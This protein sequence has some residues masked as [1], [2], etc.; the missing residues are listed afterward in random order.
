MKEKDI[1]TV[2]I[3][4]M[5][6][7]GI[8]VKLSGNIQNNMENKIIKTNNFLQVIGNSLIAVPHNLK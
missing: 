1:L 7:L 3:E 4:R 2:F 8:E 5:K 6:R